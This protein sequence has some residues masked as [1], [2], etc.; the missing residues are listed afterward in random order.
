VVASVISLLVVGAVAAVL[1]FWPLLLRLA[2]FSA[3]LSLVLTACTVSSAGRVRGRPP[4][5]AILRAPATT[6]IV[7]AAALLTT[8]LTWRAVAVAIELARRAPLAA[9]QPEAFTAQGLLV[10]VIL[11]ASCVLRFRARSTR[12]AGT[13][14]FWLAV[15]GV[16]WATLLLP[17]HRATGAG[18]FARSACTPALAG[19]LALILAGFVAAEGLLE[20]V[21][22]ARWLRADP[23]LLLARSARW[24]GFE[25]SCR[26]VGIVLLLL[27]CYHLGIGVDTEPLGPRWTALITAAA[28]GVGAAALLAA[29]ARRWSVDLAEIGAGLLCLAGACLA[30]ILVPSEPAALARRYP[31]M[32]NAILVGLAATAWL[33]N[34]LSCVWQQQ[35]DG[36]VAWTTAGRMIGPANRVA[37]AAGVVA[38]LVAGIMTAWPRLSAVPTMDHTLGRIVAG[39]AGHLLLLAVAVWSA[40]RV[41]QARFTA[42]A[43]LTVALMLVFVYVRTVPLTTAAF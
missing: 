30:V 26:V 25:T 27:V 6:T 17:P 1:D 37:F 13:V 41:G 18:T 43:V 31:M 2:L 19:G 3:V 38:L 29:T 15:L 7:L 28:A 32:F 14:L 16:V 22:R 20:R 23:M 8:L 9:D 42:L 39:V 35:L 40:R 36:T 10:W 4:G 12:A 24:P 21:R 11:T 34:W 33:L 5:G